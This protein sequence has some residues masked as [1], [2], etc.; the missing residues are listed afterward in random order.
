MFCRL[1]HCQKELPLS[2][3]CYLSR[4]WFPLS[5]YINW[6]SRFGAP[7]GAVRGKCVSDTAEQFLPFGKKRP[8]PGMCQT[9]S[10]GEGVSVAAAVVLCRVKRCWQRTVPHTPTAQPRP[11]GP[12]ETVAPSVPPPGHTHGCGCLHL[13]ICPNLP[14]YIVFIIHLFWL[15]YNVIKDE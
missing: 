10:S 4:T 8:S 15:Y 11:W 13:N 14:H 2:H 1:Q 9:V 12:R 6:S 3:W 7:E 5:P